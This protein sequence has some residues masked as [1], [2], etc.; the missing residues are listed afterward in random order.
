MGREGAVTVVFGD[1]WRRNVCRP[2]KPTKVGGGLARISSFQ[3]SHARIEPRTQAIPPP[4]GRAPGLEAAEAG[5]VGL[6][7]V[8]PGRA[9]AEGGGAYGI[10][11]PDRV[12]PSPDA[13][14]GGGGGG[15]WEDDS[16]LPPPL[17][18]SQ[19]FCCPAGPWAQ[20]G[21]AQL[22]GLP[23]DLHREVLLHVPFGGGDGGW[24]S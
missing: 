4:R 12:C 17:S 10:G 22:G 19:A 11:S 7:Y 21:E 14:R 20:A 2:D 6:P 15:G 23:E 8:G 5:A 1:R 24:D 16:P 9:V 3:C 18:L 13:D